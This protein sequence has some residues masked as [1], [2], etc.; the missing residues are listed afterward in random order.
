M[1][2][3]KIHCFVSCMQ[4]I[5]HKY[6]SS[7]PFRATRSSVP[8]SLRATLSTVQFQKWPRNLQFQIHYWPHYFQFQ[9]W[10]CM[11]FPP[12][13]QLVSTVFICRKALKYLLQVSPISRLSIGSK[14]PSTC[15][16]G[17]VLE[18]AII[19]S[20]SSFKKIVN[21]SPIDIHHFYLVTAVEEVW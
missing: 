20:D 13:L 21:F 8:N 14:T 2:F 19:P 7:P 17:T 6:F 12:T 1:K 5:V 4:L 16:S 15:I 18:S 9:K 11:Y 10:P 3:L